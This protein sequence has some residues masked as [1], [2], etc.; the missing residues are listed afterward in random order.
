MTA[1]PDATPPP[2]PARR[3]DLEPV[4]MHPPCDAALV[5]GDGLHHRGFA[6]DGIAGARKARHRLDQERCPGAAEFAIV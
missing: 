1:C 6:D 2:F 4:H 3:A 5:A